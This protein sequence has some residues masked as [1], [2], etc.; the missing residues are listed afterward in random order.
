MFVF[1]NVCGVSLCRFVVSVAAVEAE[2]HWCP[3]QP[4]GLLR[5]RWF[6]WGLWV[7]VGCFVSSRA[8]LLAATTVIGPSDGA[9]TSGGAIAALGGSA[10]GNGA[11]D[12]ALPPSFASLEWHALRRVVMTRVTH[13]Y[14]VLHCCECSGCSFD[15][16]VACD[17]R[18]PEKLPA[19]P[20]GYGVLLSTTVCRNSRCKTHDTQRRAKRAKG[21]VCV[22]G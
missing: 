12:V 5:W 13:V 7:F 16:R 14:W 2:D 10:D 11:G 21:I 4:R 19:R 22:S 9:C 20:Y 6:R 3:V 17:R 18:P 8:R 15:R 1:A